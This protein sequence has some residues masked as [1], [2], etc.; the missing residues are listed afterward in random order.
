[1]FV[2]KGRG[3]SGGG[4]LPLTAAIALLL[5]VLGGCGG[6]GDRHESGSA[7]TLD[8]AY[9]YCYPLVMMS[10]S[11]R[12]ATNVVE[13]TSAKVPVNQLRHAQRLAGPDFKDV[14]TPNVDTLYS[15]AFIDLKDGPLVF[16]KPAADRYCSAQFLDAWT[17]SVGIAG[18]GGREGTSGE[19]VCLLMRSDDKTTV[20]AGMTPFRLSGNLGW[21]IG[22][23]LCRGEDDLENVRTLQKRMRLLPL[24]DYLRGGGYVPPKGTHDPRYDGVIPVDYVLR[25]TPEQFFGEANALMRDNPPLSG[26]E[27]LLNKLRVLGVGPG[28]SF[29]P[30]VLGADAQDRDAAWRAMIK[31]V[32]ARVTAN[33]QKFLVHWGPWQYLGAPIAEFGTEYDYRAM[34]AW[35]G[36]G[37]NP[38]SAAIYASANK[39][40]SGRALKAG[41]RYKVR[42]EKGALPP[43]REGGFWSVTAY[44]DD[45]FLIA[46]PLNRYC[47]N[48]RTPVTYNADGSLELLLQPEAPK[49]KEPLK[50][51]WLPTGQGGFHLFLRIYCPDRTRIDGGWK[52]PNLIPTS[53]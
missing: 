26:D 9:V 45:D 14:V 8:D 29:D 51:N 49:D 35:R 36:L 48:D 21:I 50:A 32:Q 24:A 20:P 27:P 3:K 33:S 1:M 13:A 6:G 22:R 46:N 43:V 25:M 31:R 38:V 52:A 42:F 11:Q 17:N 12:V 19:Q 39:D 7:A 30:A 15:Q 10:V 16:V 40:S 4:V 2:S 28:L 5:V 44:G 34:V 53:E 18:T 47:I 41:T 23:T 37:A